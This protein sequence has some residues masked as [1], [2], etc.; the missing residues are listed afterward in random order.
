M[1]WFVIVLIICVIAGI[2]NGFDKYKQEEIKAENQELINK[3]LKHYAETK[4]IK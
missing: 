4:G 3:A 2:A 1:D